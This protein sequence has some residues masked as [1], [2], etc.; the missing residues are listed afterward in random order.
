M[1][2]TRFWALFFFVR[3]I[4]IRNLL[5]DM[6]VFIIF[7]SALL[8]NRISLSLFIY[9]FCLSS[10]FFDFSLLIFRFPCP[11]PIR[12]SSCYLLISSLSLSPLPLPPSLPL[13]VVFPSSLAHKSHVL[14]KLTK[15]DGCVI[16]V[17]FYRTKRNVVL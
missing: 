7:L 9:S 11:S 14:L 5:Y 15:Y 3:N 8:K 16:V 4:L 6:S 1:H 13:S 10:L 2:H 17:E 12:G